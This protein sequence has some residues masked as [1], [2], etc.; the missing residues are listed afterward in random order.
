MRETGAAQLSLRAV[1]GA[2]GMSP[3]GLYRYFDSREAL[4]TALIADGFQ[5]LAEAVER[6]RDRA[7]GADIAERLLA[8]MSGFRGWAIGHPHE[9]GLLYGDPIPG[10]AAPENGPTSVASRRVGAAL[11]PPL[12]AAW[13]AGRL[14]TS[15]P[16]PDAE[17]D[18]ASR[19][20]ASTLDPQLPGPAAAAMLGGWARL[21]G[22]VILEVFGHLN[23]LAADTGPLAAAQ[24]RALVDDLVEPVGAGHREPT[25]PGGS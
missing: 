24:L 6:S 1:A 8:A 25:D 2:L 10:F 14:R 21:H 23:W 16:A 17:P 5:A 3:A 18:A 7:A 15:V 22:L 12:L 19:R 9:F 13:R 4:L 20:W 11:L